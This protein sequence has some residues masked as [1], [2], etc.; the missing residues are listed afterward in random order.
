MGGKEVVVDTNV[1]TVAN[2]KSEQVEPNCEAACV[3]A[4]KM[5]KAKRRTLLDDKGLIIEE[6]RRNLS[7]SGQPGVEDAFFK[8]LFDNQFNPKHCRNVPIFPLADGRFREF[9]DDPRLA[10]FH[11]D[12]R[13]FV[14][15]ALASGSSPELLYAV[16]RGWRRHRQTL[17]ENGVDVVCLCPEPGA[18]E[19]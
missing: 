12:D 19:R 9:P 7:A 8:W 15:V 11:D 1:P 17:A 5:I 6:Y 13:K 16:D 4:L 14:A 3:K 18:R 2:L 10:K